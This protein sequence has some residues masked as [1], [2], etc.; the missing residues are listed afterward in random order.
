MIA[1]YGTQSLVA[2]FLG[3]FGAPGTANQPFARAQQNCTVTRLGTGAYYVT[4]AQPGSGNLGNAVDDANYA[5][6]VSQYGSGAA[7]NLTAANKTVQYATPGPNDIL[8]TFGTTLTPS[9]PTQSTF[10][11]IQVYQTTDGINNEPNTPLTGNP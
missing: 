8:I 5:V 10:V 4:I 11:F 9:D 2:Q 6:H 3:F 1:Q 7:P